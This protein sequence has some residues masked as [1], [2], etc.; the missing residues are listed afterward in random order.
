MPHAKTPP[1]QYPAICSIEEGHTK[2]AISQLKESGL[3]PDG[4]A[5]SL[6]KAGGDPAAKLL[7]T[8]VRRSVQ[9]RYYPMKWRGGKL[10][11]V[12]KKGAADECDNFRGVL[13]SNHA[14]KIIPA[15]LQSRLKDRYK[16]RVGPNQ[17]GA[18][19]GR[20]TASASHTVRS[21]LDYC[22]ATSRSAGIIYVDL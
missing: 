18:V 7:H 5:A 11:E 22:K 14:S 2:E 17:A 21:F 4:V 20:G 6:I 3:G 12:H 8:I 1:L 15:I 10:L 9:E 16:K 13:V 19:Q